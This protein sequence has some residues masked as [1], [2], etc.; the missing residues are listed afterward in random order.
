MTGAEEK[1]CVALN[2][3]GVIGNR[4]ADAVACQDNMELGDIATNWRLSTAGYNRY[5]SLMWQPWP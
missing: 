5:R 2:D 1:T 3:Y 4:V